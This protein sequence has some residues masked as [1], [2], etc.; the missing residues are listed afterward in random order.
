M[1]RSL[2]WFRD[3]RV[4]VMGL[5]TLGG[6]VGVAKWLLRHGARVTVTDLRD[7]HAL[8]ASIAELDRAYRAAKK[9]RPG[10]HRPAFVLGRHDDALFS[11][12]DMVIRNPAVPREHPLL[13]V[14]DRHGVPVDMDVSVF[15]ALCPFPVI[16][17]TG[18]KGKTTTTSLLADICRAHDPRTVVGGNI[19]ISP[20]DSLDRLMSLARHRDAVPVPVVLEL[21]S[22]QLEGLERRRMS[23]H[24]AVVTNIME[25]HLNR[26]SGMADYARAKGIILRYQVAGD[27]AVLNADDRRVAAMGKGRGALGKGRKAWFSTMRL[28]A[29]GCWIERG[30]IMLRERGK[31]SAVMPLSEVRLPGEHNRGNVL[32]AIAAARAYG[33]PV[34]AIRRAVRAFRGVAGRLEEI[35]SARGMRFYN[36]TTATTPDAA[37]AAMRTLG[38]GPAKRIVLIAGGADKELRFDAWA[39]DVKRYVKHLVLFD[40]SATPKMV[41]ALG[42][43][44]VSVTVAGA[45]SMKEALA[46]AARHA[47]RGDAVL[48][49]PGC[50]S[51]G[52][53]RNEFDRGDQF[54][55]EAERL[56]RRRPPKKRR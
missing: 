38:R 5:G 52:L 3:K 56:A 24:V 46:E 15:L 4:T 51:F 54:V 55:A 2:E 29:D 48:L 20:L 41:A 34:P 36:D 49:S 26:Y 31:V 14:A 19:R 40:G 53:F 42:R 11:A 8:A 39:K 43:N 23:P 7:E 30:R 33:I 44:R 12:A 50:A 37:S 47:V 18:T 22:W 6:G 27:V 35:A 21:S 45:R 1:T 9:K 28:R 13:A 32:A 16:G 25:D 10:V 17:V